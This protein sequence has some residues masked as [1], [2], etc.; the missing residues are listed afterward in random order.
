[1]DNTMA[2]WLLTI[3]ALVTAGVSADAQWLHYPTAGTL[4]GPDG[5][6]NL[7]A[8]APRT[9]DGRPDFSG[10]WRLEASCPPESCIDYAAAPEF[11]NFG[12]WASSLGKR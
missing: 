12:G 10:I 7:S 1:M 8:P 6:P 9:A 3:V 11:R 2:R 4:R 5:K